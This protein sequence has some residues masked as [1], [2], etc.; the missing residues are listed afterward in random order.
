MHSPPAV[1]GGPGE[2][3]RI[4]ARDADQRINT[5]SWLGG[6]VQNWE[7][8]STLDGATSVSVGASQRTLAGG[9]TVIDAFGID[10]ATQEP[11]H[12][13]L[14]GGQPAAVEASNTTATVGQPGIFTVTGQP[15]APISWSSTKDGVVREN[16]ASYGQFLDGNGEFTWNAGDW[17]GSAT[18]SWVRQAHIGSQTS[19]TA[20]VAFT[21]TARPASAPR[22]DFDGDGRT[23]M[24]V[25]RPSNG[26]WYGHLTSTLGFFEYTF[27]A[28][29][30][31]PT[32]GDFDGDGR[33]DMVVFRPSNGTWYGH[34]TSTLGFFEYTF[35]AT[36]DIPVNRPIGQ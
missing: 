20:Q 35:G 28:T 22:S 3:I 17:P 6:T 29:G 19:E 13:E 21:V 26:T 23:D 5:I 11:F 12:T 24:V 16:H 14:D 1:I 36:G 4:L 27:G 25:F 15:G 2:R 34:L 10:T 8:W 18:G 32:P 30:D 7:R 9:A 31:I 33:T